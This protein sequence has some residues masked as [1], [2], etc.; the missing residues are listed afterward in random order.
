[1]ATKRKAAI[2][3]SL[4]A[5]LV[6]AFTVFTAA[7]QAI[8]P[9]AAADTHLMW[10]RKCGGCH[11]HAGP[12]ARKSLQVVDGELRGR[13]HQNDLQNFLQQHNGGYTRED[14][15]AITAMLRVQATTPPLFQ[16]KCAGC[17][18]TAAQ[19]VREQVISRDGDLYGRHSN[20][21]IADFLN[22]HGSLAPDEVPGM[23]D[24]LARIDREVHRP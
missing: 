24:T 11:G 13:H 5:A 20:R 18:S 8:V 14:I 2:S 16:Q 6:L 19:L 3:S 21:R 10:D 12:F 1:M 23:L 22:H 7:V 17:H 15:S 9:A 4:T